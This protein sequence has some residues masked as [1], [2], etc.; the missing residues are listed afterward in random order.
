M[1]SASTQ[2]EEL[3]YTYRKAE[4]R[5]RMMKFLRRWNQ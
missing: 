2:I 5:F 4:T 1:R 3:D